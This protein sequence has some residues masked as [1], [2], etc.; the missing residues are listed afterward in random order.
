MTFLGTATHIQNVTCPLCK[1]YYK[2]RKRQGKSAAK[3][4]QGG[5]NKTLVVA[6][7]RSGPHTVEQLMSKTAL[8]DWELEFALD[9]LVRMGRVVEAEGVYRIKAMQTKSLGRPVQKNDD[10]EQWVIDEINKLK[11]QGMSLEAIARKLK[12]AIESLGSAANAQGVQ[13]VLS[14]YKFLRR[15]KGLGESSGAAGGYAVPEQKAGDGEE[16]DGFLKLKKSTIRDEW[17]ISN[18]HGVVRGKYKTYEEAKREYDR[19]TAARR[20]DSKSAH[21][22]TFCKGSGSGCGRRGDCPDCDGRG[23]VRAKRLVCKAQVRAGQLKPGDVT[24]DGLGNRNVVVSVERNGNKVTVNYEGRNPYVGTINDLFRNVEQKSTK[25]RRR[26]VKSKRYTRKDFEEVAAVEQPPHEMALAQMYQTAR[27]ALNGMTPFDPQTGEENKLHKAM[28]E[29][30]EALKSMWSEHGAKGEDGEPQDLDEM[31]KGME[32]SGPG[33]SETGEANLTDNGIIPE[34]VEAELGDEVEIEFGDDEETTEEKSVRKASYEAD[35]DYRKL[36]DLYKARRSGRPFDDK[37]TRRLA[38]ELAEAYGVDNPG[39][40][41]STAIRAAGLA[42]KSMDDDSAIEMDEADDVEKSNDDDQ[43]LDQLE[44]DFDEIVEAE[45]DDDDDFIETKSD[46]DEEFAEDDMVQKADAPVASTK[47]KRD[48]DEFIVEAYDADGKRMPNSDYYTDDRADAQ[49]TARAMVNPRKSED[50]SVEK[51]E[52]DDE[53]V[54][55]EESPSEVIDDP[56]VDEILERYDTNKGWRTRKAGRARVRKVL[57]AGGRIKRGQDGRKWLVLPAVKKGLVRGKWYI[58]Q[59][60]IPAFGPYDSREA[61]IASGYGKRPGSRVALN[62]VGGWKNEEIVTPKKSLAKSAPPKL[63]S[64]ARPG[65][66]I[67]DFAA[68]H[69]VDNIGGKWFVLDEHR[70]KV[71]TPCDTLDQATKLIASAKQ[72]VK[73]AATDPVVKSLFADLAKERQLLDLVKNRCGIN[74][75]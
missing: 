24:I 12:A 14:R 6:A 29:H 45:G 73:S 38:T 18:A 23:V 68:R 27:S 5:D 25:Q 55:G 70:Q 8:E 65:E 60:G 26:T 43:D 13:E 64:K 59:P 71:S 33:N 50:D 17:V 63:L 37:E 46:F 30:C 35:P 19:M 57:A 54:E 51:S 15:R 34:E 67:S 32:T 58:L 44:K 11:A 3:L 56:D 7:L 36:V 2:D 72:V 66:T 62:A 74:G 69:G 9:N 10:R 41:M 20:E 53:L 75:N 52:F 42:N 31:L 47:I 39:S 4:H 1:K 49:A 61:A 40:V 21:R 48:G 16:T 28:T 22:C